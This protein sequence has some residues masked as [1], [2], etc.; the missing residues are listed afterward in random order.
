MPPSFAG[1][2]RTTGHRA[3]GD[4]VEL[5]FNQLVAPGFAKRQLSSGFPFLKHA[6]ANAE[7]WPV[8]LER[9]A[10]LS[11]GGLIDQELVNKFIS[12]SA[13]AVTSKSANA[14]AASMASRDSSSA[15]MSKLVL[16][17]GVTAASHRVQQTARC[18]FPPPLFRTIGSFAVHVAVRAE[19]RR[20]AGLG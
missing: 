6:S 7:H 19:L 12:E 10:R 8:R 14:K 15:R 20:S 1:F 16:C 4:A 18:G 17:A 11:P 5:W 9:S 13:F 3:G 2:L